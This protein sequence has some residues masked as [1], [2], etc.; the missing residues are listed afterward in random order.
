VLIKDPKPTHVE[1]NY[2]QLVKV[3]E[4]GE[5]IDDENFFAKP[6]DIT[7]DDEGNFYVYDM[8]LMKILKFDKN[9]NLVKTFL[10]QGQGPGEILKKEGGKRK[11]YFSKDGHLYVRAPH[12]KKIIAFDKNGNHVKDIRIPLMDTIQFPPVVDPEG[13]YYTLSRMTN[14]IDVY[15]KNF[16]MKVTL[17]GKKQYDRFIV[18]KAKDD[19][20]NR[21]FEPFPNTYNT[22]YDFVEGNRFIVYL[23]NSSTVYLFKENKLVDHFDIWPEKALEG[24]RK[25][26]ER[27]KKRLK[28]ENFGAYLSSSFFVDKDDE[29]FFYLDC[30]SHGEK[31]GILYKFDLSGKLITVYYTDSDVTFMA[32]RDN[33]FYGLFKGQVFIYKINR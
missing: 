12:N 3:K 15:D 11:M 25:H 9:Y 33:L 20:K 27:L 10:E 23:A 31:K 2:T 13:N 19:K 28:G 6:M 8:L 22:G 32:K 4:I 5:E 18:H 30:R 14:G 17:L 1:K 24:L 21:D 16:K 7:T 29:A 26:I